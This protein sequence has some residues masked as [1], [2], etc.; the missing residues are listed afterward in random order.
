ML[1]STERAKVQSKLDPLPLPWRVRL[2]RLLE[3]RPREMAALAVAAMMVVAGAGFAFWRSLPKPEPRAGATPLPAITPSE[4]PE[5]AGRLLVHVA[6]AVARPG[7]YEFEKGA[8][9]VDALRAAGG[10]VPG[11]D[12]NSINLARP[13]S[14]G[15]RVYVPR[16]GEAPPPEAGGPA[17]TGSSAG[18]KVNI[19]TATAT[20]LDSLPGVGPVLAQRI[21]DYRSKHGPFRSVRDLMKVEGIGQKKFDALKDYVTV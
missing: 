12:V 3:F 18:Q 20:E 5:A 19:N 8:R 21:V 4:S 16:K 17:G 13:L 7:V 14:D 9:V 1:P 2:A 15:E 10:P 6:G 11:A